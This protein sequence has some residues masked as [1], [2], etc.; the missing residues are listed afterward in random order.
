MEF[1]GVCHLWSRIRCLFRI[2]HATKPGALE[3]LATVVICV[4][5]GVS[6]DHHSTFWKVLNGRGWLFSPEG[7]LLPMFF[8]L[9][10]W[11]LFFPPRLEF[12]FTSCFL[13]VVY[14][15]TELLAAVLLHPVFFLALSDTAASFP[16]I[17]VPTL[18]S[19]KCFAKQPIGAVSATSLA[20]E[21]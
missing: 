17:C 1:C 19:T 16:R 4:T 13:S 8:S 10:V 18:Q 6:R 5:Q 12:Y 7:W 20:L 11:D 14:L 2:H 21:F 3:L 15:L 9:T